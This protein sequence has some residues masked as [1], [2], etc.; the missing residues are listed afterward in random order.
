[1]MVYNIVTKDN[2]GDTLKLGHIGSEKLD[3]AID[4]DTIIFDSGVIKVD[5]DKIF[6]STNVLYGSGQ[7][8]RIPKFTNQNTLSSSLL[9]DLGTGIAIGQSNIANTGELLQVNG[10]I[11]VSSVN[12]LSGDILTW[13]DST[14]RI[15]RR[16]STQIL[17]DIG[18]WGVSGNTPTVDTT[19]L[20]TTNARPF[21]IRVNNI[22]V[23]NFAVG[24]AVNFGSPSSSSSVLNIGGGAS[25][26]AQGTITA[27][28]IT[29]DAT[30][31]TNYLTLGGSNIIRRRSLAQVKSDLGVIDSIHNQTS[32]YQSA[33]FRISGLGRFGSNS[34]YSEL[35][36]SSLFSN[37]NFSIRTPRLYVSNNDITGDLSGLTWRVII[38]SGTTTGEGLY[39]KGRILST[40]NVSASSDRRLKQNISRL[41]NA[42]ILSYIEGKTYLFGGR[43]TAGFIAQDVQ[44]HL[45]HLVN[46]ESNGFFSMDYV[47][48]IPYIVEFV[49]SDREKIK[50]LEK[51]VQRLKVLINAT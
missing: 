48:L 18:G 31:A 36:A 4:N 29:E 22:V 5:P 26:F 6:D 19:F 43:Q 3:V 37:V 47:G 39:I 40:N 23:G 21:D 51:E 15:T 38:D 17:S 46:K 45:P 16:T 20:G 1:M 9:V 34:S 24:G 27:P 10:T 35:G 49:K 44:K 25:I 33:N 12:N 8:G 11:K 2:L 50:E 32:I 13:N 7:S 41:N 30:A 28:G 42:D 14:G